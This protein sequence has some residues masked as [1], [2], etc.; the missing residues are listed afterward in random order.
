MKSFLKPLALTMAIA[1]A[2]FSAYAAGPGESPNCMGAGMSMYEGKGHHGMSRMD[3]AKMQAR[4]DKRHA[5]LKTQLK[6]TAAQEATWTAYVEAVKPPANMMA[7]S[8]ER[9]EIAKLPTPERIDKMKTLRSQ[10]MAEM[11]TAM[12]KHGEATKA[13]YA[14]LTPEQQKVFDTHGKGSMGGRHHGGAKS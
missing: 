14:A 11:S 3:P 8:S 13:L 4:M 1:V 12:D 10:R 5:N 7:K 9:A 2:G 6:I